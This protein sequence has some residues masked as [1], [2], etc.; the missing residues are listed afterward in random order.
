[1]YMQELM[2]RGSAQTPFAVAKPGSNIK[3]GEAPVVTVGRIVSYP[4]CGSLAVCLKI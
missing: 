1:M 4:I 2:Q 3:V